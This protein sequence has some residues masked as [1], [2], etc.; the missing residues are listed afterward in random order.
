MSKKDAA[1]TSDQMYKIEENG[2]TKFAMPKFL[3]ME[4]AGHAAADF[5]LSKF[6]SRL[7]GK[8][9][10]IVCGTGNNGGDGFVVSRHLAGYGA[11]VVVI[12]LGSPD[13]IRTEEAK[14]TWSI[15]E[16]M[17]DS[18]QIILCATALTNDAITKIS[19]ADIVVDAIFGTGI[20]G[21]ISGVHAD[22][23]DAIND[24]SKAYT[25]ALDIPSGLDPNSGMAKE[26][27]VNA[28]ATVTF[29]RIKSGMRKGK[30]FTG[31]IQVERIGI[32]LEAE[33][34]VVVE[35]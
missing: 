35:E 11:K 34:G 8:K 7:R 15:I 26:K 28:D 20:K 6:S 33:R 5:L 22:A 16:R 21:E 14:M 24:N 2:S 25:L 3:M 23:I 1:I 10:T 18:V 30:K 19:G 31:Q 17:K 13:N 9:I 12:L 29:H 4:N 32:P 27:C